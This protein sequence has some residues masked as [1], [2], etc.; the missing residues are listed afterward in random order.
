M[1]IPSTGLYV[2]HF[3]GGR[4]HGHGVYELHCKDAP[5]SEIYEGNFCEGLFHGHGMMRN[6]R[7]IY[8]GEYQANARSGYG[9]LEDLVSGDKYMGMFADNK[10]AGIGSC[11][12][13][14]GD[15]FEG[16]FAGDDVMGNG[17]AVFEND[18]YYEGELTL[19]GPNG[20]GEYYMP[21]GDAGSVSVAIGATGESDDGCELIGNKIFGQLSGSWETVRIQA[22]ELVLN[23]RFPKYPR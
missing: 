18:Y 1:V 14:R 2:G 13:N 16:N 10:R 23:R 3:K 17:V 12:T 9:V 19:H 21:S 7:Y 15:Y 8:V 11:I 20:R 5:E 6:N 22:G 4:F